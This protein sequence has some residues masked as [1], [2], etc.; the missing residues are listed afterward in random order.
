MINFAPEERFVAV[1]GLRVG[2][3]QSYSNYDPLPHEEIVQNQ[4][5]IWGGGNSLFHIFQRSSDLS[6]FFLS[7]T[8]QSIGQR[9]VKRCF[10]RNNHIRT[11]NTKVPTYTTDIT[12]YLKLF[13]IISLVLKKKKRKRKK[14]KE[15]IASARR[16][17]VIYHQCRQATHT[18][19]LML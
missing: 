11:L 4:G 17:L 1:G 9:N 10:K 12:V 2:S 5:G 3:I 15:K 19:T 8:W 7:A 13:I 14:E 6:E 16:N 18:T